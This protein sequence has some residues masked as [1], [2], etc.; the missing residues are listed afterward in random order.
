[1]AIV[2]QKRSILDFIAERTRALQ[3]ELGAGDKV[4]LD[5]YLDTC[6]RSNGAFSLR[7]N[8]DLSGVKVPEM[9]LAEQ[10]IRS[11]SR[12]GCCSI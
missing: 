1:V 10:D 5:G 9:P 8:R 11:T 12:C 4:L 2:K 6:E 7:R 3:Q